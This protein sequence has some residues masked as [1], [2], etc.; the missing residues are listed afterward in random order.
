MALEREMKLL[1]PPGFHLPDLNGVIEGMV[2]VGEPDQELKATY[3]DTPDLRLARWGASLR[4]R[5]GEGAPRW[6]LKLPS[7]ASGPG[8]ARTELEFE[9]RPSP[10]PPEAARLVRA[11]VRNSS[12]GRV[13]RLTTRRQRVSLQDELGLVRAVVC[14]DEVSVYDSRRLTARFRELEVEA[15]FG[16][17]DVLEATAERLRQAGASAGQPLSKVARA[18]GPVVDTPEI[19]TVTLGDAATAG[20]VVR[21]AIARS[22]SKLLH[23]DP[24]VRLGDDIEQVHQARVATRRLRSDLRTFRTLVDEAW[25]ADLREQVSW[26]ADLLGAVRDRD[27]LLE[28]L[29]EEVTS[30]SSSDQRAAHGLLARLEAEQSNVR[31]E[32]LAAM[33]GQ[34]YVDLLETLLAAAAAPS[35]TPEAEQP[36]RPALAALVKRSLKHVEGAVAALTDPPIDDDL[37]NIR[38]RSKRARYAAEA[39]EPV[40][41]KPA[42]R[43]ASAV[44]GVQT[45]LGDLQDAV[46]T[47]QWLRRSGRASVAQSF[48][49]GELVGMQ[50]VAMAKSRAA[51][52]AAWKKASSPK[53]RSWLR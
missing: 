41:G 10:I 46:V 35:L 27:V 40:W 4:F 19:P 49:A 47:E 29:R 43:L 37:H 14:D 39:A 11:Y 53:L 36:A 1:A 12:L 18:L 44:A 22:V 24:G 15:V 42:R 34:R 28:R 51:F 25:G 13:A 32:L 52:P 5:T 50:H 30:V 23:H 3:Y 7:D 21:A 31:G 17:T 6:T 20:D 48:L 8:L 38:I 33:D 26:L 9:G 45:V 2:A 16:D